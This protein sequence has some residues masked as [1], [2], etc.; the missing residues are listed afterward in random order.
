MQET[1][2]CKTC[3]IYKKKIQELEE[4]IESLDYSRDLENLWD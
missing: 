4:R 2:S 1:M 3:L